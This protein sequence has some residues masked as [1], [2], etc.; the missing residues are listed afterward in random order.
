VASIV[1]NSA[2][3][4]Y[5][6]INL[7]GIQSLTRV[8]KAVHDQDPT[9]LATRLQS[10]SNG[11]SNGNG[12]GNSSDS[13]GSS[14]STLLKKAIDKNS[15]AIVS[16]VCIALAH[17]CHHQPLAQKRVCELDLF[18]YIIQTLLVH[19]YHSPVAGNACRCIATLT[20]N[21]LDNQR[22]FLSLGQ[23]KSPGSYLA[24]PHG[25]TTQHGQKDFEIIPLLFKTMT[26][27]ADDSTL[28]A[29]VCWAL[30]NLVS[31]DPVL[32]AE[33]QLNVI[34][35]MLDK[36]KAD[37]RCCEYSCRLLGEVTRPTMRIPPVQ[38]NMQTLPQQQEAGYKIILQNRHLLK[39]RTTVL[40]T[41]RR[42]T[43]DHIHSNFVLS[44]TREIYSCLTT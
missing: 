28:H 7:D 38:H 29:T 13:S 9:G 8:L 32:F 3:N 34:A 35:T 12:N 20:E 16:N 30:A 5:E 40:A 19:P 36:F 31:G 39:T 1:E 15:P 11:G 23:Q 37:E 24:G 21:N 41:L 27:H 44:R 25:Q 26:L 43:T 4:Q 2:S 22:V 42:L 18:P 6:F 10:G 14:S 33:D 17:A